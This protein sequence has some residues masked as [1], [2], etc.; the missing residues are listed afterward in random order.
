MIPSAAS[1][2]ITKTDDEPVNFGEGCTG[3]L[4]FVYLHL[5]IFGL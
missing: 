1:T 5:G 4:R 2:L 3:S